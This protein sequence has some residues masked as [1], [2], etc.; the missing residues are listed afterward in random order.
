MADGRHFENGF[1]LSQCLSR[2]LSDFD[3]TWYTG[4]NFHSEHG[5]LTKKKSKFFKFKMADGRHIENCILAIYRRR[6]DRCM[7]VY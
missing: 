7:Y 4:V 1:A 6:I 5:N 2:E 3:Q